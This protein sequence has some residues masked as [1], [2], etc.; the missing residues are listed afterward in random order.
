MRW[1]F[2]QYNPVPFAS[3]YTAISSNSMPQRAQRLP[4]DTVAEERSVRLRLP[5]SSKKES[6]ERKE[7]LLFSSFH[8]VLYGSFSGWCEVGEVS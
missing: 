3:F 8:L 6:S 7:F 4:H 1:T 2:I 5:L